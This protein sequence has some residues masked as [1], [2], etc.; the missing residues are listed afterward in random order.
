SSLW[1]V[2]INYATKSDPDFSSANWQPKIWLD[3]STV[4][5]TATIENANTDWVVLNADARSM[6]SKY[7]FYFST[8][9]MMPCIQ[10]FLCKI[11]ISDY[12]RVLYDNHFFPMILD[13]L[14]E[15]HTVISLAS[16]SQMIDDY[17]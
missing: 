16:R 17:F 14:E 3:K 1:Y 8:C 15:S 10:F 2:P 13:Q 5:T 7:K 12:Y 9:L 6:C 4:A 11:L